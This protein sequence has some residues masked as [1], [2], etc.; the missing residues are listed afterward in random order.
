MRRAELAVALLIGCTADPPPA[1]APAAPVQAWEW[2]ARAVQADGTRRYDAQ[3]LPRVELATADAA[4]WTLRFAEH[5]LPVERAAHADRWVLTATAPAPAGGGELVILDDA[6]RRRAGWPARF[7]RVPSEAPE[8]APD[9]GPEA[10]LWAA[11]AAGRQAYRQGRVA[12]AAERWTRAAALADAAGLPSEAARRRVALAE[13]RLRQHRLDEVLPLLAP[14]RDPAHAALDPLAALWAQQARATLAYQL[15]DWRTAEAEAQ[16]A[17]TA[18]D[19]AGLVRER[20]QAAMV[21]A[22]AHLISGRQ[23]A[24][25]ATYRDHVDPAFADGQGDPYYRALYLKNRGWVE[26]LAATRAV[27]GADLVRAT[28]QMAEALALDQARED[29]PQTALSHLNLA[30][31]RWQA[32]DHPAARASLG[33]VNRA[34]LIGEAPLTADWLAAELAPAADAE[35]AFAALVERARAYPG[36]EEHAWRAGLGLGRRRLARGD[37]D[38][39]WAAFQAGLADLDRAARGAPLRAGLAPFFADRRALVDE[40]LALLVA[41]GR[42]AEAF[43]VAARA[44]GRVVQA[45]EAGARLSGLGSAAGARWQAAVGRFQA[46]R[47]ALESARVDADLVYRE[48][49]QRRLAAEQARLLEA[50]AQAFDAAFGAPNPAGAGLDAAA[51]QA[52]LPPKAALALFTPIQGRW[53]GF[54]VTAEALRVSPV[55]PQDPLT[56][57][58]A[59]LSQ[60]ERL[61]VVAGGLPAAGELPLQGAPPLAA[62]LP[63]LALP[64]PGLLLAPRPEVE[65]P[66]LVIADPTRDLAGAEAEGVA[67]A[68]ALPGARVLQGDAATRAAVLAA[69]PGA[70]VVH[71]AGHGELHP[72]DPWAAHL[73]LAGGGRLALEDLLI[74]RPTT[75]VVVLSGCKTGARLAVGGGEVVGLPEALLVA[76]ARAVLATGRDLADREALPFLTRFYAAGGATDPGPAFRAAVAESVAAGDEAWRAFRLWGR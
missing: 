58:A 14:T 44:A 9:A 20:W 73:R 29:G 53:H 37:R 12:E 41:Q 8:A 67:V 74:H 35:A 45:L 38:G 25:L 27:P 32:G 26:A 66:P 4:G 11:V 65:G 18:A 49:D 55:R 22:D 10:L 2:G 40:A 75:G 57:F 36:G 70:P 59:E 61:F 64:H 47:E 50:R 46:A 71:F 56:P 7:G 23:A 62:R 21:L 6:G 34:L 17:V 13:M 24:A 19:R 3:R 15:G 54:W 43:T 63:V 1:P 28:A 31:A 51:I 33:Q 39:A 52:A 72:R 16:A 76:G 69:L 68:A 30:W 42:A 5:P 60:T 48:A